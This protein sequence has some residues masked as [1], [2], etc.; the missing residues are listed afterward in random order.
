MQSIWYANELKHR[1]KILKNLRA[2]ARVEEL[3]DIDTSIFMIERLLSKNKTVKD[4][5]PLDLLAQNYAILQ[6]NEFIAPEFIEFD[7]RTRFILPVDNLSDGDSRDLFELLHELY[8]KEGISVLDN[9]KIPEFLISFSK[10][11]FTPEVLVLFDKIFKTTTDRKGFLNLDKKEIFELVHDF[12]RDAT[13][14]QIFDKFNTIYKN[15]KKR[16]HIFD[17][18]KLFGDIVYIPYFKDEFYIQMSK[19]NLLDDVGTLSHE[20]GHAIQFS[21]NFSSTLYEDKKIFVEIIS[22]FFEFLTYHYYTDKG[23][24]QKEALLT[25][26]EWWN[27]WKNETIDIVKLISFFDSIDKSKDLYTQLSNYQEFDDS[28]SVCAYLH[29]IYVFSF[30]IVI[31]LLIIYML[32]KERAFYIINKIIQIDL[33]LPKEV[34]YNEILKL[35]IIP[36]ASTDIYRNY[37]CEQAKKHEFKHI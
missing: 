20:F 19:Q 13:T 3:Y 31:E 15:N 4:T 22:L 2:N 11:G 8:K 33:K 6:E 9:K 35:G 10:K 27:T 28:L 37:L 25:N 16:I 34:Y 12:Y 29:D 32:D 21:T 18:S 1:L 26:I 36:T 17:T 5:N 23:E 14:P 7:D 24:Y 30:I